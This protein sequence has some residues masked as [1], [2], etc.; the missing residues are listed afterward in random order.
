MKLEETQSQGISGN[1][2]KLEGNRQSHGNYC[3]CYCTVDLEQGQHLCILGNW[4]KLR[5]KEFQETHGNSREIAESQGNHCWCLSLHSRLGAKPASLNSRKHDKIRL[6]EFQETR[7]K[8]RRV[9]ETTADACHRRVS[10]G[11][12]QHFRKLEATQETQGISGK[13]EE[14]AEK[15]QRKSFLKFPLCSNK[16][17]Q[18]FFNFFLWFPSTFHKFPEIPW[19]SLVSWVASCFLECWPFS[20][21]PLDV[22]AVF[23]WP[24][25]MI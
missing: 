22:N 12:G 19:V 15:S 17:Q 11:K 3:W 18:I 5:L 20:K 16:H 8:L 4:R 1:S 25:M 9:K 7:G 14:I 10:W 21:P 6:K 24:L 13:V 23:E 2:W